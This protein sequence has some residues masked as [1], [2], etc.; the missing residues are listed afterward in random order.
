MRAT[1]E[2]RSWQEGPLGA[3]ERNSVETLLREP[4]SQAGCTWPL[5][6]P[7]RTITE[8]RQV[9]GLQGAEP[10]AESRPCHVVSVISEAFLWAV[11]HPAL[12]TVTALR[13][14]DTSPS[15]S[16]GR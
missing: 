14:Q 12:V 16:Q 5:V 7:G 10:E 3:W 15:G 11:P 4:R 9:L 2:P 6:L 1:P 8:Y 13:S